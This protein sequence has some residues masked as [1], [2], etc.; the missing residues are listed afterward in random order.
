[1]RRVRLAAVAAFV[2]AAAP[3]IA[4]G[5]LPLVPMVPVIGYEPDPADQATQIYVA[6]LGPVFTGP[7]IYTYNN[8]WMRSFAHP[9][10]WAGGNVAFYPYATPYPYV[11]HVPQ[12]PPGL[13]RF[14]IAPWSHHPY[15]HSGRGCCT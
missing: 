15:R 7:G 12:H 10:D 1:M 14:G 9:A 13:R 4:G 11:R 6:N 3:A 2:F 5:H 8:L